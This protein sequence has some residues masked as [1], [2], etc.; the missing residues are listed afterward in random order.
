[1]YNSITTKT[2]LD[3]TRIVARL[4][5]TISEP[6]VFLGKSYP[7]VGQYKPEVTRFT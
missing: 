4:V 6:G 3:G 1:M 5:R 2:R 7:P